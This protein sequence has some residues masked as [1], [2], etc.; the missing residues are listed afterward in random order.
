[1]AGTISCNP[2]QEL[3]QSLAK[4][5]HTTLG[6]SNNYQFSTINYHLLFDA[7]ISLQRQFKVVRPVIPKVSGRLE[8]VVPA[9]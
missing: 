4:P 5:E 9:T 6:Q 7:G 8:Y 3:D 1:M 2:Q